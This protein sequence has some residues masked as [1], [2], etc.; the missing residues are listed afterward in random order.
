M[1]LAR[2]DWD[3]STVPTCELRAAL[4]WEILRESPDVHEVVATTRLWLKGALSKRKPPLSPAQRKK[5]GRRN[6]KISEAEK[7]EIQARAVFQSFIP[8]HEFQL[9]QR[10]DL[11]RR[12]TE[13]DRWT[14]KHL[15]P[16][17][18]NWGVPWLRL[19]NAERQRLCSI[20]ENSRRANVVHVAS[21]WDAV[22]HFE[23]GKIDP[24][25]PL[26]FSYSEYTSIL[27]T[28]NWRFTKK[29]ILS[30]IAKILDDSASADV[31]RWNARGRKNRD[32]LVVLE[33][34]AMM[35]LL[36]NSTLSEIR[37]KLP[38]AW[39]IYEKRKW[40][41]ERRQALK[42]FRRRSGYT[43]AENFFPLSWET[44]A[45]RGERNHR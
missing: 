42:D 24:G 26:K 9:L 20:L 14:A 21:W 32:M 18:S 4:D 30:A 8:T 15:R 23:R 22:G 10:W 6:P 36:H 45:Q 27:L 13:Y 17:V 16:L 28:I 1:T 7:A 5:W 34:I 40:Y 44:K 25:L 29:R 43:E 41:D 39:R 11:A 12:R 31:V 19:S 38:E 35:R 2:E 33:R 3:F 37:L